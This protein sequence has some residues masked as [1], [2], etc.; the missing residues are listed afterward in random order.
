[1]ISLDPHVGDRLLTSATASTA[2]AL[3]ALGLP[4]ELVIELA[5]PGGDVADLVAGVYA[6]GHASLPQTLR[7]VAA[8]L[9]PDLRPLA[10]L[11]LR[12]A[13]RANPGRDTELE[14]GR[15]ARDVKL[16]RR[17]EDT[18]EDGGFGREA[19]LRGLPE[20][21][22]WGEITT[23][24]H[25]ALAALH[26]RQV[27]AQVLAPRLYPS[28]V[29]DATGMAISHTCSVLAGHDIRRVAGCLHWARKALRRMLPPAE[30]A[31]RL[32]TRWTPS[33]KRC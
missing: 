14:L 12:A 2:P 18:A 16:G 4:F 20:Y 22:K 21:L 15:A 30:V 10:Q 24:Q 28:S 9:E 25:A 8:L 17:S 27:A 26:A 6:R 29:A 23:P 5:G 3:D 31:A 1:M 7:F 13:H 32:R 11:A 19:Y 33:R